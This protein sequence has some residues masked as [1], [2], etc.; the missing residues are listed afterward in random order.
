MNKLKNEVSEATIDYS[1]VDPNL[2]PKFY[3]TLFDTN[4]CLNLKVLSSFESNTQYK[5]SKKCR[6]SNGRK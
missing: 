2:N 1:Q 4:S 3:A 6:L 5:C